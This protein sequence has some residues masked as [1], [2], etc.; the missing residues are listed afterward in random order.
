MMPL[1][2][3][4]E[5]DLY[6]EE[7][8]AGP[9]LLLIPG[10]GGNTLDWEA[11]VPALAEHF[12]VM[13][14][15]NRGAGRSSC[16]SGPCTVAH[17]ADDA[18]MLLDRLGVPRCHVVGH[19]MGG[20]IA[21]ELAL[22]HPQLVD[23]LV[24]FATFARSTPVIDAWLNFYVS[25]CRQDVDARG[26]T[27]GVMPW[28]LSPVFMADHGRVETTL[29][30]WTNDSYP[31][32]ALGRAA[33]A[34]A[35]QAYDSRERL[36]SIAAPTLVLVAA[37]DICTPVSCSRELAERIPGARLQILPR[38][39]HVP[40]VEYPEDINAALLAFLAAKIDGDEVA[41]RTGQTSP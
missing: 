8:G 14:V 18:A 5:I 26:R 22:T 13:A 30:E 17:M 10:F 20:L 37:E 34:A 2:H 25:N 28:F 35:C 23:R 6:Y 11:N 29:D 24:L 38:G 9:P 4:N 27:L 12:R 36:P 31:A 3:V 16:P 40:S 21:Q 32:P 41:L 1:C 15:D 33:Q 19:S 7:T 39:G